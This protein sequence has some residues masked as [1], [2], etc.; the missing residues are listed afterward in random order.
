M[1]VCVTLGTR[2]YYVLTAFERLRSTIFMSGM[3]I[4]DMVARFSLFLCSFV[5][6]CFFPRFRFVPPHCTL[7][8]HHIN[9]VAVFLVLVFGLLSFCFV[10]CSLPFL[11]PHCNVSLFTVS[12]FR[13]MP[14]LS[15]F[16]F[17]RPIATSP[18]LPYPFPYHAVS[19]SVPC[20]IFSVRYHCGRT[21]TLSTTLRR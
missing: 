8:L 21:T 10:F 13:T 11:P 9:M 4:Y 1:I 15:R 16:R 19:V 2:F 17:C 7:L 20:R 18:C 12:I 5:L 3:Y 6:L 14:Y